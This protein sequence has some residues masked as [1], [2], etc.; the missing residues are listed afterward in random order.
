MR[1]VSERFFLT[2][3]TIEMKLVHTADPIIS[4]LKGAE[5][6]IVDT[7]TSG[8]HPHRDGK[9]LGGI[10]IKVLRGPSFPPLGRPLPLHDGDA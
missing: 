8:L 9:I 6:V 7:E 4:A 5:V 1:R 10:G 2:P 3:H